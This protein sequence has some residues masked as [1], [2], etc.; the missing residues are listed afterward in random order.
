MARIE[1][2]DG[3]SRAEDVPGAEVHV[4]RVDEARIQTVENAIAVVCEKPRD[5]WP[6]AL[7][8][9][10]LRR[11]AVVE[12]DPVQEI[13]HPVEAPALELEAHDD[14][15]VE[16]IHLGEPLVGQHLWPDVLRPDVSRRAQPC[17]RAQHANKQRHSDEPSAHER[18]M[19]LVG[20]SWNAR[21]SG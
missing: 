4:Q 7:V 2:S 21:A 12:R 3:K 15:A 13:V 5:A 10:A 16:P 11:L 17:W 14:G 6:G 8:A 1:I 18:S 9:V 20:R 19:P